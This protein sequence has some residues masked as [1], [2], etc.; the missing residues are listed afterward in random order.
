MS[1]LTILTTVD[2]V[3]KVDKPAPV[4][5]DEEHGL[6]GLVA[7]A[8]VALGHLRIMQLLFKQCCKQLF[9]ALKLQGMSPKTASTLRGSSI[10]LERPCCPPTFMSSSRIWRMVASV[11]LANAFRSYYQRQ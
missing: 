7:Q 6:E 9:L 2:K 3:N 1:S 5:G 10:G 11:S 8:T 4:H